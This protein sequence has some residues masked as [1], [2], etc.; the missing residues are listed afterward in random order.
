MYVLKS[1]F[2]LIL[3]PRHIAELQS[4]DLSGLGFG[5]IWL[6]SVH[7]IWISVIYLPFSLAQYG[8]PMTLLVCSSLRSLSRK[9]RHLKFLGC[10]CSS[11]GTT[12]VSHVGDP[13]V[14][15]STEYLKRCHTLHSDWLWFSVVGIIGWK[16]KF[17][18]RGWRLYLQ[19]GPR[20][21]V[22]KVL[23]GLMLF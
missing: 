6:N 4:L 13:A 7:W 20:T 14:C 11:S 21:N 12:H 18:L 15:L 2:V 9:W 19:V 5:V 8:V 23:W 17:S 22:S 10:R 16:V 3:F 1:I